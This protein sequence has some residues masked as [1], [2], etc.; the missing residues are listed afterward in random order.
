M[1]GC[2]A[3][4]GRV[5][6]RRGT[7]T[8]CTYTKEGAPV[9]AKKLLTACLSWLQVQKHGSHGGQPPGPFVRR[10]TLRRKAKHGPPAAAGPPT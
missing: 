7:H 1:A 4:H 8:W 10:H 2:E 5:H 9:P 6:L 3:G